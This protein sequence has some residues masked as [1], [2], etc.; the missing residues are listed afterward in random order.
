MALAAGVGVL[1]L[2]VVFSE[3]VLSLFSDDPLTIA[4]GARVIRILSVGFL[5]FSLSSVYDTAQA[6]AGDTMSAMLINVV[7][8]WAVQVPLA[9][10]LS[11]AP[12][13][14]ADGI[15]IALVLGY[16]VQLALM[17]LRFRQ[18]RWRDKRI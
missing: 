2:L 10:L 15:W 17:W 9:Y 7:S 16:G 8:L 5:A 14:G 4:S 18:G 6:G 12:R 13:T 3:P 1:G 11:R